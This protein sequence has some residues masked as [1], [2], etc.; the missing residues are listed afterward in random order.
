VSPAALWQIGSNTK[1][2]TAVMLLQLKAEGK[3]SITDTLGRW[4]PQYP[5]RRDITIRQLLNLT[6]GIPDPGNDG[7][8]P[9]YQASATGVLHLYVPRS[10]VIVALAAIS[11]PDPDHDDLFT[12]AVSV[13]QALQKA[14]LG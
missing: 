5:A 2:F 9:G 4:L 7:D 1:T 12:L 6:S 11:S 3:L 10:G 13:Y 8:L 14:G